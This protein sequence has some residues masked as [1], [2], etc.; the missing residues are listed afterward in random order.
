MM[1]I[2]SLLWNGIMVICSVASDKSVTDNNKST[3]KE[4]K[5]PTYT[6]ADGKTYATYGGQQC[7]PVKS[8]DGWIYYDIKTCMPLFGVGRYDRND[9]KR[10]FS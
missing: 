9:W 4:N 10:L 2:I 6:G 3:S 1:G 7:M 5:S 8:G